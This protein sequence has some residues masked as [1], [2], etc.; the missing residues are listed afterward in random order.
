MQKTQ[1]MHKVK[2]KVDNNLCKVI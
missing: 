1:H 2:I